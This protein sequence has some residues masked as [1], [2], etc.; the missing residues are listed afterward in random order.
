ASGRFLSLLAIG[1]GAVLL[2]RGGSAGGLWLDPPAGL[3]R[4]VFGEPP[5]RLAPLPWGAA[6]LEE[7]LRRSA[8][9]WL[10][11]GP[12]LEQPLSPAEW[13]QIEAYSPL[14]SIARATDGSPMPRG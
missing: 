1:L 5:P 7:R 3:W 4:E 13:R 12:L 6:A 10:C 14:D 11:D 2:L 9:R 8:E